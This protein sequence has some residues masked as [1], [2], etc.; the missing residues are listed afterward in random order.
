MVTY[1][2][3]ITITTLLYDILNTVLIYKPL[4]ESE[5]LMTSFNRI[6]YFDRMNREIHL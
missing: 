4:R 3:T 5:N 1:I 2:I 6:Q